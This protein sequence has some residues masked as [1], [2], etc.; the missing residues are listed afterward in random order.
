MCRGINLSAACLLWHFGFLLLIK[1]WVTTPHVVYN[2]GSYAN[3]FLEPISWKHS[4][5]YS[6]GRIAKKKVLYLHLFSSVSL[7]LPSSWSLSLSGLYPLT[8]LAWVALLRANAPTST[9]LSVIES[10][11]LSHHRQM[12][13]KELKRFKRI[14]KKDLKS[15]TVPTPYLSPSSPI[16]EKRF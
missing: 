15:F 2:N 16:L 3:F 14:S 6:I 7:L 1:T 9:A 10:H 4:L 5:L 13:L 11:K 8:C 12:Y